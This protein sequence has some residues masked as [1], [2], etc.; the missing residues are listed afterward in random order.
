MEQMGDMESRKP[1]MKSP[2]KLAR[3]GKKRGPDRRTITLGGEKRLEK[4]EKRRMV[5]MVNKER[6]K[7]GGQEDQC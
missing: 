7:A 1:A 2:R 3:K 5:R 6:G 4:A